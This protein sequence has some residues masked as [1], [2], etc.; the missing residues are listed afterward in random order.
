VDVEEV[1]E[2]LG[3]EVLWRNGSDAYC[4]CPDPDHVDS[5][6]SFHVCVEDVEDREGRCRLGWFNCW[7]HPDEDAMRG[8]NFLDLVAKV[9]GGIWD[10]WPREEERTAA[11]RWL[12]EEFLKGAPR[13][14]EVL[15]TEALRRREKVTRVKWTELL[16]PPLRPLEKDAE[17]VAYL[18]RRGIDLERAR[19]LEISS[20][21]SAGDALKSVLGP[22]IPAVLFPIVWRGERV[23]WFA[24]AISRRVA[25]RHKG[26][27]APVALGRA[28]VLWA[29]DG[30]EPGAP[31]ILVEGIFDAE[32]VRRLLRE[33]GPPGTEEV[34]V[35]A[36]LGGRLYPEQARFLRA[37]PWIIHMADG[38]AG[39]ETLGETVVEHL[40]GT[41]RVVVRKL[42]TG[43]D[44]GD[45]PPEVVLEAATPPAR[46]SHVEVRFRTS[47]R[48][49]R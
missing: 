37:A 44:P 15:R 42:P 12:R 1:L 36:V 6:P 29:P 23:N 46:T 43:T 16:W 5:N 21:R 13:E 28:G 17:A 49:A 27:Y 11:A 33:A 14:E 25:S 38:D 19:E 20:V 40:G 8:R 31:V 26:R 41:A 30:L 47:T 45:A 18:E 48:R 9:R 10:R 32:R 4:E 34:R 3:I 39:G 24:R 35:A 7:S 22:T 2:E